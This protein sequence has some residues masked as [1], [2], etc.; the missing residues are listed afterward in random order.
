VSDEITARAAREWRKERDAR[1]PMRPAASDLASVGKLRV[2]TPK[3]NGHDEINPPPIGGQLG[4][5]LRTALITMEDLKMEA[6]DWLWDGSIARGEIHLIAGAPES[7]KTTTALSFASTLSRGGYWPDETSAKAGN[8]VIWTGED[9]PAKTI[10]PRLMQ[11]GA[12]PKKIFIVQGKRD[13]SGKLIPFNP[14]T[15]LPSLEATAQD[16]PGGVDMLIID[17]IV[18]VVGGKVDNGNNAGHREKLQPLVDFSKG[19]NCAVVGITHFTKGTAGKD[20]VER[21]TGSLA[22]AAV[23]RVVF[24]AAKNRKED[25]E[26]VFV[27]AKNNLA[28]LAGGYGYSIVGAPLAA[29]GRIIATKVVWGEHIEGD[30]REIL[31]DAEGDEKALA[32]GS[33]GQLSAQAWLSAVL[34]DGERKQAEI[35]AE[36]VEQ[37]FSKDKLFRASKAVGVVKRKERFAGEWFWRLP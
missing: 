2:L 19:I 21:V 8:V 13:E 1:E 27:M 15:D 30:P 7:G 36:A 9:N 10:K 17:P 31:A 5:P 24:A 25:P 29:D 34:A 33:P 23:A 28:P 18:S 26:R 22:F 35:A 6:T 11:M 20:P 32:G 16:I 37:G 14:A 3:P 4:R 12:D